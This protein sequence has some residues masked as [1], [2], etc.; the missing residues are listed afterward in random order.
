MHMKIRNESMSLHAVVHCL[1]RT[2]V[3][4]SSGAFSPQVRAL[5]SL[6]LWRTFPASQPLHVWK[7]DYTQQSYHLPYMYMI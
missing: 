1:N 7:L 3:H 5:P 2:G 4:A 6:T